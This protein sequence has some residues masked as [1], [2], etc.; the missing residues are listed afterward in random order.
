MPLTA[1]HRQDLPTKWTRDDRR[2]PTRRGGRDRRC[3]ACLLARRPAARSRATPSARRASWPASRAGWAPSRRWTSAS[4]TG[5]VLNEATAARRGR[6]RRPSRG[7]V[8][9]RP[10]WPARQRA[11]RPH[12][13]DRW[14]DPRPPAPRHPGL[15][16]PRGRVHRARL[17][18]RRGSGGRDGLLQL[19]SAQHAAVA[20]G[21]QHVGHAVRRPRRAGHDGA[22]HPHL[23]RPDPGDGGVA[24][25]DL[26]RDAGSRLPARHAGRDAHARLPPD[27]RPGHRPPHHAR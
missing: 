24:A 5:Q 19:R 23:A 14:A 7:A 16:T 27:R 1:T 8:E 22:P 2:H 6:D 20:P 18:G 26:R 9:G 4:D 11:T 13:G 21:A 25:A 12:R 3:H 17:P 10:H 15:A